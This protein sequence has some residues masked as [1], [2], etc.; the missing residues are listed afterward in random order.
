[1]TEFTRSTIRA[2]K[3]GKLI[4]IDEEPCRITNIQLSKPGKHGSMKARLDAVSLFTG[5]R[6][7]L[8]KPAS[9]EVQ[10]PILERKT[11]QVV[12]IM[13]NRLQL[14]D[15]QTYETYE[16]DCPEEF[17]G[18]VKQGGEVEIQDVMGKKTITRIK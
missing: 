18:E 4:I 8:V 9:S 7:S 5:S 17:Q 11:A 12:A 1:V 13:G 14:M 15:M 16:L 10:V 2:L 6:K 3:P